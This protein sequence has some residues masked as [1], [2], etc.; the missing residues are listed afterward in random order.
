M[1]E[2]KLAEVELAKI[3]GA[4]SQLNERL[5]HFGEEIRDLR[6]EIKSNFK[7][8]LGIFISMWISVILVIFFK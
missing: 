6:K 8:T 4:V 3:E 7:W 1:Q 2:E 5:N